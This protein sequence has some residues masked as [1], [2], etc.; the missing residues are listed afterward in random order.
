MFF[1]YKK[2]ILGLSIYEGQDDWGPYT[3]K[4]VDDFIKY[5]R[6]KFEDAIPILLCIDAA[7]SRYVTL[8]VDYIRA[9]KYNKIFIVKRGISS[10]VDYGLGI[11][12]TKQISEDMIGLL[13]TYI[14]FNMI[15]HKDLYIDTNIEHMVGTKEEIV[16][17]ITI[18]ELNNYGYNEFGKLTGKGMGEFKQDDMINAMGF[19]MYGDK[20]CRTDSKMIFDIHNLRSDQAIDFSGYRT[21]NPNRIECFKLEES[22]KIE[23]IKNDEN[24][25]R[26]EEILKQILEPNSSIKSLSY[27]DDIFDKNKKKGHYDSSLKRGFD[28]EDDELKNK[29]SKRYKKI[30]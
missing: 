11:M 14:K 19:A 29:I 20:L 27:N 28:D 12:K 18:D 26:D 4:K 10:T 1:F 8:I 21:M 17:G 23:K 25:R 7:P 9:V 24:R 3:I 2:K 5:L 30:D 16:L 13:K 22:K 15:I 6:K